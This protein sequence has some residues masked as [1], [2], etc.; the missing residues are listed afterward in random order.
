MLCGSLSTL[1]HGVFDLVDHHLSIRQDIVERGHLLMAIVGLNGVLVSFVT[2]ALL[3]CYYAS[4][5]L[6]KNVNLIP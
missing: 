2:D 1:G 4:Y 3:K 5:I 6:Q